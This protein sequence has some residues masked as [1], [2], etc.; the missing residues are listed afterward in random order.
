MRT[1]DQIH[2][3]QWLI[4]ITEVLETHQ[5]ALVHGAVVVDLVGNSGKMKL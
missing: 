4:T 3:N 1:N 2:Y 5:P